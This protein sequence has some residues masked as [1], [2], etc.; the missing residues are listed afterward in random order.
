MSTG[1][2]TGVSAACEQCY[3][4]KHLRP[5]G[6]EELW[7]GASLR[8]VCYPE[9]F[10]NQFRKDK[11]TGIDALLNSKAGC[12]YCGQKYHPLCQDGSTNMDP[13]CRYCIVYIV[14]FDQGNELAALAYKVLNNMAQVDR[15][16][17]VYGPSGLKPDIALLATA[18]YYVKPCQISATPQETNG[19]NENLD[20]DDE[21]GDDEECDMNGDGGDDR[22]AHRPPTDRQEDAVEPNEPIR[23]YAQYFEEIGAKQ[24]LKN[25]MTPG[26]FCKSNF[27]NPVTV[28]INNVQRRYLPVIDNRRHIPSKYVR[29]Y[30]QEG[31]TYKKLNKFDVLD[32]YSNVTKLGEASI[33]GPCVITNPN[34]TYKFVWICLWRGE[35]GKIVKH[36]LYDLDKCAIV[37]FEGTA[38]Y[39]YYW[40][41]SPDIPFNEDEVMEAYSL[42]SAE[43]EYDPLRDATTDD[44]KTKAVK[45]GDGNF[46]TNE[47][48]KPGRVRKQTTLFGNE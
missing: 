47:T 45:H 13:L 48:G 22:L 19:S 15:M 38:F 3:A 21:V 26:L 8:C 37:T 31:R 41:F 25:Q 36:I 42:F 40:N 16:P 39:R 43:K 10:C 33:Y 32:G 35:C 11:A 34:T 1:A 23:K 6:E 29:F 4:G 7:V 5:S 9:K 14:H 18:D 28:T 2:S 12:K 44:N 24:L 17:I 20:D 27:T 46:A 30:K